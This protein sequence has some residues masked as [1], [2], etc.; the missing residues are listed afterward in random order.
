[1]RLARGGGEALSIA[2]RIVRAA[3]ER[4]VIAFCGY[5]G[6]TDWYLA[7]NLGSDHALDGHLLPGLSPAGVPRGLHGTVLPFAYNQIDDLRAIVREHGARLAGVVME[8]TRNTP[9]T[10]GFLEGVRELCDGCG[11]R[12]VFDEVTT[13]LRFCQGGAH[14]MYGLAPDV[15]V[16]AKALGNGHPIAA[17]IGRAETMQ[18]AQD[19]FI[20]STYW[21]EGVG[22]AAALATLAVMRRVDVPGHVRRI[23]ERFREGCAAAAAE[24]RLPLKLAG[25]PALTTLGFDHPESAALL[26]L[27]TV[28]MLRR[29]FLVGGGFY[30]TL[31]HEE[32]HVDAFLAAAGPVFEELALSLERGDTRGRIGGAVRQSGFARLT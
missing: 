17:V 1:V 25:Y 13:G 19:S 12:L 11:A 2:V 32:R 28:R 29:G 31:A 21:T 26:T 7:A 4:D 30:P 23:G 10:A 16:F 18:A 6:W 5:H 15:A 22:P 24:C 20:S 9:P 27:L 3:T 14:L 8:P